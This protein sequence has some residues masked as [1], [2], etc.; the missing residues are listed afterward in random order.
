MF[1][2][3]RFTVVA[4]R[5]LIDLITIVCLALMFYFPQMK[6]LIGVLCVIA[7]ASIAESGEL[8]TKISS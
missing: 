8:K 7:F 1:S 2:Y 5:V 4:K 3:D 6:F